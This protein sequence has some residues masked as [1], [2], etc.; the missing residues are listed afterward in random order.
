[1]KLKSIFV[2]QKEKMLVSKHFFFSH[3]V[4][5]PTEGKFYD[6]ALYHTTPTFNDYQE[7]DFGKHGEKRRGSW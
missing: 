5:H 1:M 6:L 7:E 2:D 3:K 4:F